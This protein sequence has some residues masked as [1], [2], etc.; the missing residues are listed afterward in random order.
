MPIER[1]LRLRQLGSFIS[2]PLLRSQ[3]E[4]LAAVAAAD[5]AD[6]EPLPP[7]HLVLAP[8]GDQAPGPRDQVQVGVL[9]VDPGELVVL[10]IGVVV[11]PLGAAELVAVGDHRTALGEE[12]A[13]Q[14]VAYLARPQAEDLGVVGVAL[15][16]A[17]SRSG[18]RPPRRGCPPRWPRCASRCS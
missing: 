12:H 5:G 4:I 6:E 14:Q 15:D 2:C 8:E 13:G 16:A 7:E 11:A 18:C 3:T 9:P 10:A 17:S 1:R